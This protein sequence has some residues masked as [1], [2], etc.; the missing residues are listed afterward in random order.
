MILLKTSLTGYIKRR[1]TVFSLLWHPLKKSMEWSQD[2]LALLPL[3]PICAV[4]YF[5]LMY[6]PSHQKILAHH[7]H[8]SVCVCFWGLVMLNQ[9][10]DVSWLYQQFQE[11][12]KKMVLGMRLKKGEKKKS[13]ELYPMPYTTCILMHYSILSVWKVWL[14][15]FSYCMNWE[16]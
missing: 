10:S 12:T 3:S 9:W 2:I 1:K 5:G 15:S 8:V 7:K 11:S 4:L 13:K 6:Q 16:P 14:W